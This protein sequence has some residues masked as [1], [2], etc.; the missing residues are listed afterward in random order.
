MEENGQK[1]KESFWRDTV[2]SGASQA[3]FRRLPLQ[4][5]I[6]ISRKPA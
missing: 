1:E 6:K 2:K 4:L 5:N 3:T